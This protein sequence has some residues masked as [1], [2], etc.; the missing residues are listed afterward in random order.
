VKPIKHF[1]TLEV[2]DAIERLER[3]IEHLYAAN[4]SIGT[5]LARTNH[6]RGPGGV[7]ATD[8]DEAGVGR[9]RPFDGALGLPNFVFADH[10]SVRNPHEHVRALTMAVA[11]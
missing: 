8:E 10:C 6:A 7:Y 2:G 1:D 3:R 9:I 11:S 4:R 5:A